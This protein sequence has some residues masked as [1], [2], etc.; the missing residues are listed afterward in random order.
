MHIVNREFVEYGRTTCYFI[1]DMFNIVRGI[2]QMADELGRYT[3]E[4][5]VPGT[6]NQYK[7]IQLT[8][9]TIRYTIEDAK[10]YLIQLLK[11]HISSNL[12][13]N[14]T[15]NNI[16][17]DITDVKLLIYVTDDD[18][19]EIE[20]IDIVK[21]KVEN[22]TV[23]LSGIQII[24]YNKTYFGIIETNN[25]DILETSLMNASVYNG[26]FNIIMDYTKDCHSKAIP[27]DYY[28]YKVQLSGLEDNIDNKITAYITPYNDN[29]VL[30]YTDIK[31]IEEN[32]I[33]F[34]RF[35]K[36]DHTIDRL[37]YYRPGIDEVKYQQFDLY[38]V[39]NADI[40]K[41]SSPIED[42]TLDTTYDLS[43]FVKVS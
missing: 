17:D 32:T 15:I 35:I 24:D 31:T 6:P 5:K 29:E 25:N 37:T 3:V 26:G 20:P 22:N 4:Y 43:N 14:I 40:Y 23:I 1:D 41:F 38:I 39:I 27:D 7:M 33:A 18:I 16:P 10:T 12:V 2:V 19:Y 42:F 21:G 36:E 8:I 13:S 11:E 34:N 30:A 28:S 9:D